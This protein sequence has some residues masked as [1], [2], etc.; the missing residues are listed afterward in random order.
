MF[1]AEKY[2]GAWSVSTVIKAYHHTLCNVCR[3]NIGK[4]ALKGHCQHWQS[5]SCLAA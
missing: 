2:P 4:K 5:I 1:N 3:C